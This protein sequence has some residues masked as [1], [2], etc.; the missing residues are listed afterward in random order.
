M[1]TIQNISHIPVFL[2]FFSYFFA[3][4]PICE[5]QVKNLYLQRSFRLAGHLTRTES[6]LSVS[7]RR[8]GNKP[9]AHRPFSNPFIRIGGPGVHHFGRDCLL[10]GPV[11]QNTNKFQEAISFSDPRLYRLDHSFFTPQ[12]K[13]HRTHRSGGVDPVRSY[14]I[15]FESFCDEPVGLF[16]SSSHTFGPCRLVCQRNPLAIPDPGIFGFTRPIRDRAAPKVGTKRILRR[17]TS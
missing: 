13:P 4:N 2:N 10:F 14:S 12:S 17:N 1:D 16:C 6:D 5:L 11:E 7:D 3:S 15:Q 8:D 9:A